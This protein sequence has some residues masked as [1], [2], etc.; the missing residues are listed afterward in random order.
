MGVDRIVRA[1]ELRFERH[2]VKHIHSGLSIFAPM[3]LD[4]SGLGEHLNH[5]KQRG[6]SVFA[7]RCGTEFLKDFIA[8]RLITCAVIVFV[9]IGL[10]SMAV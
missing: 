1:N 6:G 9:F 2:K 3:Y 10:S 4:L 5:C 8:S 7:L